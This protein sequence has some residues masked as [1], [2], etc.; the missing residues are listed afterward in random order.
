MLSRNKIIFRISDLSASGNR[1]IERQIIC[2]K[3]PFIKKSN[4]KRKNSISCYQMYV[5]CVIRKQ[6]VPYEHKKIA[7]SKTNRGKQSTD[8]LKAT[9]NVGNVEKR[10]R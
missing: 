5:H 9:E 4:K 10:I 1:R 6:R 7:K 3:R 8:G 2:T